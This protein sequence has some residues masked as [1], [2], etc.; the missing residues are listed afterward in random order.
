MKI[1]SRRKIEKQADAYL[2]KNEPDMGEAWNKTFAEAEKEHQQASQVYMKHIR[3]K[4]NLTR[5]HREFPND[6]VAMHSCNCPS[7]PGYVG[8][9][10]RLEDAA[11]KVNTM[12]AERQTERNKVRNGYIARTIRVQETKMRIMKDNNANTCSK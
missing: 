2:A 3:D 9:K 11:T 10:F 12:Y 4:C 8:M 5:Y 7:I 1:L 6:P